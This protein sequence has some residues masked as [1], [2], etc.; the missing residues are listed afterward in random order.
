MKLLYMLPTIFGFAVRW[1]AALPLSQLAPIRPR[2]PREAV[3]QVLRA[4][5]ISVA[6]A[7]T[8]DIG[9]HERC[10]LTLLHSI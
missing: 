1:H 10:A 3:R 4:C 8:E 7:R 6:W 5:T 2:Q 9:D